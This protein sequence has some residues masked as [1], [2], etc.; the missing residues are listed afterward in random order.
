MKLTAVLLATA[1]TMMV[2]SGGCQSDPPPTETATASIA[3]LR[4][5]VGTYTG[6]KSK[7]IYVLQLDPS[8]GT[9]TDAK[10]AAETP[11]PSFLAVDP[12]RRFLYAVNEVDSFA[13]E[14]TGSVSAFAIDRADVILK[15]L[16]QQS[17]G[18]RGPCHVDVDPAGAGVLVA[19]YGGGSVA[20][21]PTAP[22]GSLKRA[23]VVQHQGSS[24]DKRRQ[25]APHAHCITVA[26][27]F[28][29]SGKSRP[30]RALV[31][32][33]G[34]DRILSYDFDSH[35][36]LRPASPPSAPAD[37]GSG[38]RHLAFGRSGRFVYV[39]NEMASTVTAYSFDPTTGAMQSLQTLST[40][41]DGYD[42]SNNSTAEI[43]VHP[44]GKFVYVSNRGHDS[45]AVFKVDGKTGK[46]APA[47]HQS[48]G[49]KTPR[50]FGIDPSGRFL[51]AAN[52]NSD[53]VV[54]LRIDPK[55]GA[56]KPTG[57]TASVPSPVCVVFVT[58]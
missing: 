41:P 48:T 19:N 7:G 14:K 11:S 28:G 53:T 3:P 22:D 20:L 32:D 5:Y 29:T 47:G 25:E 54:I 42:K 23:T 30:G 9:L 15:P 39:N 38:P 10:L 55:S 33:L 35:G 50:S 49:G 34:L 52:Q 43:A 26:P 8:S 13:G 2:F 37:P 4:V 45:I 58:P 17:S 24:V 40:L 46:L 51:L 1:F 36:S 21:L 18:G 56:L 6:A 57:I 27:V 12:T 44:T 16:N 31:A